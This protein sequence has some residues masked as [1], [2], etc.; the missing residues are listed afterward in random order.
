[1]TKQEALVLVLPSGEEDRSVVELVRRHVGQRAE[2]D[3]ADV[4][5]VGLHGEQGRREAGLAHRVALSPGRGEAYPPVGQVDRVDVV[6]PARA[7][8]PEARAVDVD[9]VDVERVDVLAV[10]HLAG[11]LEVGARLDRHPGEEQL[12]RVERQAHV[13]DRAVVATEYLPGRRVGSGRVVDVD[14]PA[15][16][17]GL[18]AVHRPH[19][20]ELPQVV[21]LGERDVREA[22]DGGLGV[23]GARALAGGA[24][25]R[26][27]RQGRSWR[28]RQEH[29]GGLQRRS[30]GSWPSPACIIARHRSRRHTHMT[31]A[32]QTGGHP[33]RLPKELAT[34]STPDAW[35]TLPRVTFVRKPEGVAPFT[36]HHRGSNPS[37]A[38]LA[39]PRPPGRN[40]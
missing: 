21:P 11:R 17:V 18:P 23:E 26:A 22:L 31:L 29:Q 5:A 40:A 28:E 24:G 33:W 6:E 20:E 39:P 8:L 15:G 27:E 10:A 37:G 13:I 2:L 7:D 1:M 25:L 32:R 30:M 34:V 38:A 35:K 14:P 36:T 19:A 12:L 16:L 4:G 3:P 9:L